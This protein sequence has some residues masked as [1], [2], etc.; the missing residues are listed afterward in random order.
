MPNI[1]IFRNGRPVNINAI[2]KPAPLIKTAIVTLSQAFSGIT[3]PILIERW[4]LINNE[5]RIEKEKIYINIKKG[6]DSGE[7]III[8]DKGNI[9]NHSLKGDIKV[10]IK[11]E[12]KSI[13]KREGLNLKIKKDITLKESLTGFIFDIAHL[14][15]KKYTINNDS[16]NIIPSNYLKEIDGL[17]MCRDEK[18]GK[19]IMEFN[20]IFPDKLTEE[21]IKKIKEIL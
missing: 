21:Q 17:G 16:G 20:I 13:F 12:N 4:I 6:T 11:V 8:K 15:G 9:I 10:H 3:Y 18:T 7:I 1:H 2:Q 14:N 19:L 5:K